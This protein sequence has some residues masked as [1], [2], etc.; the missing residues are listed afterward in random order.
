M[1]EILC[2]NCRRSYPETGVPYRCPVCGG[3]YDYASPFPFSYEGLQPDLPGIWRYRQSFGLPDHAPVISLGEGDT[4]LE[5]RHVLSREIAFKLEI[6][7]PTGSFK[8]RGSAV[9]VS[10]L[11]SR[12]ILSAV[13]DSSGN[14]G[15]SFAAYARQAGIEASVFVP[16]SASG[17]KLHQIEDYG[18]KTIRVMGPRSN[19]AEAV[20]REANKGAVYASHAYLPFGLA[21]YATIAYE[22]FQQ[23]GEVPG[24]LVAPVGQGNLL[25]GTL[26]GFQALKAAGLTDRVPV[27]VGV[28]ALVC[29]PLWAVSRY[30]AAGLGWVTE[31]PSLA[32]GV[33]VRHPVRGDQ[34]LRLVAASG[35]TF[36]AVDER[37]I[38][39]GRDQLSGLGF[40]IEPTSALVWKALQEIAGQVPDPVLV[41]LTGA[42]FK[43]P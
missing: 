35:G 27:P 42:G 23:M 38:Q 6:N 43:S 26:Q 39:P 19:A 11:R 22:S 34:I 24:A 3:S 36:V 14:A 1:I 37:E 16:D 8:D 28:Q 9:L 40:S 2:T 13:E 20:V 25:L 5:W 18:A 31:N 10:F 33:V 32:E 15:A 21:G 17:P 12:Q 30:G 29:A 4:P 7:N 41:I